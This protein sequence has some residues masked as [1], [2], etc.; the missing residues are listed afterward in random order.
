MNEY[1]SDLVVVIVFRYEAIIPGK[2]NL[3]VQ[4]NNKFY[5]FDTEEKL[6]KFL[7][8]VDGDSCVSSAGGF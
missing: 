1:M 2:K 3:L 4:Y 5:C 6:N 8:Y 7:R